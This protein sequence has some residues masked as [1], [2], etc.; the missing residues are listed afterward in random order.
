MYDMKLNFFENDQERWDA[1]TDLR[2]KAA[3]FLNIPP[4]SH[5]LEV[6][7]G[8]A[9]Y[10]RIIAKLFD[11]QVTSI[12]ANED[13]LKEARKKVKKDKLENKVKIVKMDATK[14]KFA[15]KTFDYVV[16]FIGWEDL[17]AFSGESAVK[18]VI[19]EMIRVAK[20]GGFVSIAFIPKRKSKN[21]IS[22]KDAELKRFMWK[23]KKRP[24]YFSE[25]SFVS[26]LKKEKV[27][28]IK[29]SIIK[30][31]KNRLNPRDAKESIKWEYENYR[32]WYAS[33]VEMRS[34]D[35]IMQKFGKFID[36]YGVEARM[37]EIIVLIGQK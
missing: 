23:S 24:Q 4:R 34:P 25:E 28:I 12:E 19:K 18:K 1:E 9:D 22:R 16:N 15:D 2:I 27:K 35:Q 6:L 29:R 3:K 7:V 32:R 14:M 21:Y 26:L 36:K 31:H 8:H 17:S 5:V 13:D 20:D 10:G 37:P 30:P 33:D 11:A